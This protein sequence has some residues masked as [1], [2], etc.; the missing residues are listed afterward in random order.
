MNHVAGRFIPTVALALLGILGN[1]ASLPLFFGVE[2]I[3]GSIAA[4]IAV[5]Q[6][7]IYAGVFVAL[8]AGAY[9]YTIWG[10]PYAMIIFTLEA[11]F[12]GVLIQR[13]NISLVLA[14]ILYWLLIGMPLVWIFYSLAIGMPETQTTLILL[15]QPV[16]GIAN[17][18]IATYLLYLLPHRFF[19]N[20]LQKQQSQI[21]LKELLFTTLLAISLSVTLILVIYQNHSA[22]SNYENNI[23]KDMQLYVDFMEHQIFDSQGKLNQQALQN[24]YHR[25][26]YQHEMILLSANK[27]IL[28]SS[29]PPDTTEHFLHAGSKSSLHNTL[30]LWMPERQGK[31]LMLW[32]NQAFYFVE[33]TLGPEQKHTIFLLQNSKSLIN[34]LQSDAIHAFMLLFGLILVS[35]LIALYISNM[36]TKTILKLTES[37][38]DI[39]NK[40]Q[41]G[42]SIAWPQSAISEL[43]QLSRQAQLMSKSISETFNDVNKRSTAIIE[44]SVDAV[45]TI[46]SKGNI[47]SFNRAAEQLF[48]YPRDTLI[49]KNV[50]CLMPEPYQ[51]SHDQYINI[52]N[53]KSRKPFNGA[54]RE[55]MGMKKD[56]STFPI[57]LSLTTINLQNQTLYTGIVTDI[58]ERKANEKLK[59]EFIS[60]VSH[61]LR[62]P[63]TSIQGAIKL[64]NARKDQASPQETATMLEL[65]D[66]NVNRLAELINDLL[67]FEKL[68]SDGIEYHIESINANDLL[69]TIIDDNR[70]MAEQARI[71]LLHESSCHANI[72]VDPNRL[73]QVISNF[74]SNAIKFSPEDSSIHIGCEAEGQQVKIYVQ[75]HGYG[76][77]E[78][79]KQRVFQRFSQ[80]DGSDTKQIQRG[81]GLG[82]AISKRMT[83]DM[84]GHIGFD[85]TEGNGSTFFV[86]FELVVDQ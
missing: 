10:H 11:L 19:F 27:Q 8:I 68:D 56:G 5:R 18:I 13:K 75:D 85:S 37:T 60:T 72:A 57:E 23:Q 33:K 84:G 34:S 48:G 73:S 58:S 4:L 41:T 83:E 80:A 43:D 32:W 31:P 55:L 74:I 59:Q 82:L 20:D 63:L 29:L 76:I 24:D 9:T 64:I 44:A 51:S 26:K 30:G 6:I 61:E 7:G 38:R 53:D 25:Y 16:N 28:S 17:A 67:D 47:E 71:R 50:K 79:F 3:F 21:R 22:R 12:V 39:T 69:R 35:G 46:N 81:T 45:I 14:N 1:I 40:L 77:P 52:F 15:K 36:L 62:T 70:P 86:I 54:R 2:F 65:A 66:R 78:N 42:I 49:G